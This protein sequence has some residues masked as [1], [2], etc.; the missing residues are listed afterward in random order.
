MALMLKWMN[1]FACRG[2]SL[3]PCPLVRDAPWVGQV[4]ARLRSVVVGPVGPAPRS[5][6]G[7][8]NDA[9]EVP[10]LETCQ[11]LILFLLVEEIV[12]GTADEDV[13]L[14]DSEADAILLAEEFELLSH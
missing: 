4:S 10:I 13:H 12:F 7:R 14:K 11:P 8:Q 1:L 6:R 9:V 3:G 5:A 2:P